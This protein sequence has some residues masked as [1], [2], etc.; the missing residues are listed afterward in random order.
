[1]Q[2]KQY[3]TDWAKAKAR[4]HLKD[5]ISE[6]VLR[7]KAPKKTRVL[8]FPGINA[9]EITQVYDSLGIPR[10]NIVGIERDAH[11]ADK[12]RR[13]NLGIHLV[14]G[15]LEDFVAS[16]DALSF[17]IVSLDYTG[18]VSQKQ[19]TT[20][21]KISKKQLINS[22]IFHSANLIR[23]D[24]KSNLL[25][26]SS[27]TY[28][29]SKAEDGN[30]I[31]AF[32][33]KVGELERKR[34]TGE[35]TDIKKESYTSIL[36]SSFID[37]ETSVMG[38]ILK[39]VLGDHYQQNLQVCE[40]YISKQTGRRIKLDPED[41]YKSTSDFAIND[42]KQPGAILGLNMVLNQCI[43]FGYE[44][45]GRELGMSETKRKLLPLAFHEGTQKN[46]SYLRM[47]LTQYSYISESG[48]PMIGD[49]QFLRHPW[50][51]VEAS[52]EVLRMIGFPERPNLENILNGKLD[53]ALLKMLKQ[54]LQPIHDHQT[55]G[56]ESE[57]IFL[58]NSSKQVLTKKKAIE[59]F[60]G[61]ASMD[62]VKQK[63]RGW[64][65]K[66]LAQW[67]AHVTMGT[68]DE[69][70]NND[71]ESEKISKDEAIDL[72]TSGIPLQEISET[73]HTSFSIGQLRSFKAH[74]ARGTYKSLAKI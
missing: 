13:S 74:L 27:F 2:E 60:K 24:Q 9:T 63:Y 53:R 46:K 16:R 67:K 41:P 52:R 17:D 72:I 25:Y 51:L 40:D 73:Y 55:K 56:T 44:K 37:D 32:S 15:S 30:Y 21:R 57:R 50:R 47:D 26:A 22:F 39:F 23:R 34:S 14:H 6:T 29:G 11:I 19:I 62:D 61:G 20:I 70:N 12:L 7:Y 49:I 5:T 28:L 33:E 18:P 45:I 71:E 42:L 59:E 66:P 36:E 43:M 54:S 68:Y 31:R 69:I 48:S 8:C 64:S 65:N 10:E 35:F 3:D 4:E 58:G 1:M 38:S